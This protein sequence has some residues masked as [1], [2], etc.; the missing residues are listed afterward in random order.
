MQEN[1]PTLVFVGI[2]LFVALITIFWSSV[3]V[4]HLVWWL[5]AAV[6]EAW[7]IL[8][9]RK[10]DTISEAIWELSARPLVPWIFGALT[11]YGIYE[12]PTLHTIEI[13][14]WLA[15]QGHFFWQAQKNV[16]N[17]I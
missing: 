8:N 14:T 6:F 9:H 10:A 11:I 16:N 17:Q 2:L 1:K 3:P 13:G 15:L 7:T 4:S 12:I 5:L